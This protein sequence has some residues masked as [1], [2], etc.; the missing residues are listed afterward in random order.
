MNGGWKEFH[1][2]AEPVIR[3][4]APGMKATLWGYNG[5]SPGPTIQVVEGDRVRMFVTNKLPEATTIHWHGQRLPNGMDGVARLVQ[6]RIPIG[7]TYV[8]EF[9]TKRAGTLMYH[10]HADEM[11]QMTMGMMGLWITHPKSPAEH[12]VDRDFA[13]LLN[14]YDIEPGASTPKTSTMTDFNL[15]TWNSRVFPGIDA[16]APGDWAFHCHKAH[17]TMNAMGHDADHIWHIDHRKIASKIIKIIPDY[18]GDG[19]A[20]RERYERDGYGSDDW[21]STNCRFGSVRGR[22]A[23]TQGNRIRAP[24]SDRPRR[25]S[26]LPASAPTSVPSRRR[27]R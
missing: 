16:A 14:A 7:R 26:S 10:P 2:I 24:A 18:M 9:E 6:T 3:E 20:R 21:S 12:R 15:W 13:F 19:R 5:S 27:Y 8:Y 11:T 22:P 23:G 4:I 1:L 25:R 17:H